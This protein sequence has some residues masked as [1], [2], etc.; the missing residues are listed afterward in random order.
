MIVDI[1]VKIAPNIYKGYIMVD[2][3]GEK[4]LLLECLNV[5][6]DTMVTSL[7]HYK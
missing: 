4:Q 6:D 5:F 3:K 7:L 2:K 1:L